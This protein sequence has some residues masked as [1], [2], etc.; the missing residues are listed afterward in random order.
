MKHVEVRYHYVRDMVQRGIL[1]VAKVHT[2]LNVSDILTKAVS[3]ATF[4]KHR[5]TL[6]SS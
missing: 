1:K 3:K 5:D 2:D 6:V 4:I